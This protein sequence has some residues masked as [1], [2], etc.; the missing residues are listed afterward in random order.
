MYNRESVRP[1]V[2]YLKTNKVNKSMVI[3]IKKK[4]KSKNIR[5]ES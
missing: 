3:L 4:E 2:G 1:E 5:S